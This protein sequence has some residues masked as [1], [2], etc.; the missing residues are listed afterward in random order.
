VAV[1]LRFLAGLGQLWTYIMHNL[2]TLMIPIIGLTM[3]RQILKFVFLALLNIK[4]HF[5]VRASFQLS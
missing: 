2:Y 5:G 4:I 3:H 1:C